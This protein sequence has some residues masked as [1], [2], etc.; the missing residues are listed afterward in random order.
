MSGDVPLVGACGARCVETCA[1]DDRNI[2]GMV[3]SRATGIFRGSDQQAA[4]E[5]AHEQEAAAKMRLLRVKQP[6]EEVQHF[7][8]RGDL[9]RL[10]KSIENGGSVNQPNVRGVTPLMLASTSSGKEGVQCVEELLMRNADL[11]SRDQNGWSC[12]HHACRNG[13]TE[14]CKFL[15]SMKMDPSHQTQDNRTNLMLA[16]IEGKLELVKEL[17]KLKPMRDQVLLQDGLGS[18]ALHF[19]AKD[20]AVDILRLLLDSHAK[21]NSKDMDGQMPLMRAAES[22]KLECV[23]QLLK[24]SADIDGKDKGM[25]S[26][27]TFACQNSYEG[28]AL[29]LLK[30]NADPYVKSVEGDTPI[31]LAEDN[32]LSEFKRA[33]K[34]HRA[35]EDND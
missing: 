4:A 29:C 32:G 2:V 6:D 24:R 33:V 20:G 16:T 13:K 14:V 30:K 1:P 34:M 15:L 35:E 19:A 21:V 28:V 31:S 7:S 18:S 17:L 27:L 12:M 10:R 26:A 22:G 11:A 25:R 9:K 3:A 5:A 23:K 8:V